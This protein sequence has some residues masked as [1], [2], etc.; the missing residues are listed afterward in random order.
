MVTTYQL[1]SYSHTIG[2][3]SLLGRGFNNPVDMAL[4]KDGVMYV[5]NRAGPEV[6]SRLPNKRVTMCTVDEEYLGEFSSGGVEDGQMMWPSAITVDRDGNVYVSDEALQR[7]TIFD[8]TGRYL[9]KWGTKGRGDGEF[10]RPSSIAFDADDNLLVS[11]SLNCRVQR[12]TREGHFL[13]SWGRPG[14]CGWRVQPALGYSR[15]TPQRRRAGGRLA[16]RP[17]PALRRRRT[18]HG[19]LRHVGRRRRRVQSSGR[20]RHR[21]GRQRLTWPTGAMSAYRC[22]APMASFLAEAARRLGHFQV[23]PRILRCQCRRACAS[24]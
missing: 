7:I 18:P 11:D 1:Y 20:R 21:R 12:Y 24:A 23:G 16:Q 14:Q 5:L 4:G 22:C 8:G 10:N 3:Y 19:Y 17:G 15:K 6:S 2:L 13:E 9:G